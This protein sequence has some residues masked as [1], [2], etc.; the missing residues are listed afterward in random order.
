MGAIADARALAAGLPAQWIVPRILKCDA[1]LEE[2]EPFY[3]RWIMTLGAAVIDPLPAW[4]A[5][6]IIPLPVPAARLT[7][8]SREVVRVRCD[9][10]VCDDTWRAVAGVRER[11][12][13]RDRVREGAGAA[14]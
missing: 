2:I 10:A 12:A 9:G 4:S 8:L 5:D 11:T 3:D 13:G 1:T 6:P 14:A 7:Q